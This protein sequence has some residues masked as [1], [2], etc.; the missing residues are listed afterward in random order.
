MSEQPTRLHHNAVVVKDLAASRAFYGDIMGMPLVATW[1]ESTPD[2]GEYCHAFFGLEDGGAIALF[3]FANEEFYEAVKRP[4]ALSPF[5]HFAMN[6]TPQ[7]QDEIRSRADAAG[8]KHRTTDH[9]YCTSLYLNDPDGHMVEVSY[10]ADIA[11]DNADMIR[12]RAAAELDR[13]L[14]GDHTP[15]NELR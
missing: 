9:G 11:I 12:E 3:Q 8:V 14:G 13:W 10:D 1:C 4:E 5:H 6:G 2:L 7:Y 15:N